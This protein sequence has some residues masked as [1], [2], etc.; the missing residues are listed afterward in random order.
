MPHY[1]RRTVQ[2]DRMPG[3]PA[4]KP[5]PLDALLEQVERRLLLVAL[6]RAQG[7][8]S[9]AAELLQIWRARLIRRMKALH[10]GEAQEP[11]S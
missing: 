2:L 5:M 11:P 1:L 3:R 6:E 7:N 8:H 9:R 10:I 4:A